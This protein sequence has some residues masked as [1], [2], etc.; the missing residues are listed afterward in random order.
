MELYLEVVTK[1]GIRLI[2]F[3]YSRMVNAGYVGRD[4]EEARR[5][6]EELAK[7]GIPGPSSIPTLYPVVC[8]AL[9]V[10]D[11]TTE[12][13]GEESSGE[14]EYVL[15]IRDE[16]EIYVGVGSDH[17]DRCLEKSDIARSKQICPNL[18][19]RSVWPLSEVID[20]WD[21][22]L[23]R[24]YVSVDGKR[25]LYQSGR[26]ELLL[27]AEELL[28][29][30]KK[31]IPGPLTDLVVFSGTMGTVTGEFVFGDT[32]SA[33]LIDWVL[34]RRLALSYA[35]RPLRYLAVDDATV[36]RGTDEGLLYSDGR[37]RT[38]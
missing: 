10:G 27:N 20:H 24:S 19:S 17:T 16:S 2:P 12:V 18:L 28:A 33:E 3:R 1:K 23:M 8:N 13:Y 6:I 11:A 29:F 5:H 15:L 22:L 7:K 21:T 25:V 36:S 4:Q 32:F 14:V 31:K 34:G 9:M 30:V 35:V 38:G 26:L 37:N